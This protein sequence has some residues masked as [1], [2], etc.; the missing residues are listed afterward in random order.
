MPGPF[1]LTCPFPSPHF[2]TTVQI[3]T[4]LFILT[5]PFLPFHFVRPFGSIPVVVTN[6][7]PPDHFDRS[8]RFAP[9]LVVRQVKSRRIPSFRQVHATRSVSVDYSLSVPFASCDYSCPCCSSQVRSTDLIWSF[10]VRQ[11]HATLIDS[12]D[13]SCRVVSFP[14][15]S[16]GR[17]HSTRFFFRQID[18]NPLLYRQVPSDHI[19][20][21]DYAGL[22]HSPQFT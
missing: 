14:V 16:T 5:C 1:V 7:Y 11:V 4:F 15:F 6:H 20:P 13:Y 21:C 18:S 3:A 2:C 10:L 22:F 19:G 9:C 17:T 8:S 12:I